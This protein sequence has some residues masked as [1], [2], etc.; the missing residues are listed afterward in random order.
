MDSCFVLSRQVFFLALS[1]PSLQ[2]QLLRIVW[3]HLSNIFMIMVM[4][5]AR[6]GD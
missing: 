4:D 5:I 3:F 2:F 1:G 6:E